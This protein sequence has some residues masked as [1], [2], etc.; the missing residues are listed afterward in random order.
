MVESRPG[1]HS[2]LLKLFSSVPLFFYVRYVTYVYKMNAEWESN[3]MY[4]NTRP[5][6]LRLLWK[7][8]DLFFE[9]SI[10]QVAATRCLLPALQ[11]V[12]YANYRSMFI[13]PYTP[14]RN[15]LNRDIRNFLPFPQKPTYRK[16][17][18]QWIKECSPLIQF[19]V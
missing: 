8:I 18:R 17:L 15:C 11:T 16:V 4:R 14:L 9:S 3:V 2:Q 12:R 6:T 13:R 1:E 19:I 10:L 5:F 7:K